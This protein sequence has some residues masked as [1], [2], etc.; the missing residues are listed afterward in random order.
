LALATQLVLAAGAKSVDVAVTHAL[1]AQ[2][3]MDVIRAAGVNHIWST[4][5]IA[6]SSNVIDI[7]PTLAK[8]WTS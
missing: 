3:A 7:A 1:F 8:A 5:C 2:D 6:H 4:D